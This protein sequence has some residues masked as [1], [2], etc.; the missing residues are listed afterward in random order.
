MRAGKLRQVAPWLGLAALVTA[1]TIARAVSGLRVEG[2]WIVPDEMIYGTLGRSLWEDGDLLVFGDTPGIYGVVYPALVG[3]PLSL[4]DLERG[5]DALKPLQALVMSLAAVPA[6]VWARS[7]AGAWWALLAAALTLAVPDLLYTALVMSEVVF[8]PVM[9]VAAWTIARALERP[10]GWNQAFLVLAMLVAAATRLQA[11]VLPLVLLTAAALFAW[12]ERDF[13]RVRRLWPAGAVLAGLGLAWTLW[14]TLSIGSAADALGAYSVLARTSFGVGDAARYVVYHAADLLLFTGLLAAC[15]VA[16]LFRVRDRPPALNALLATAVSLTGWLLLQVGAFASR[17][18]EV[19]AERNIVLAAPP[20]F[21]CFATWLSLGAPRPRLATSLTALGALG[22]LLLLPLRD[23]VV[24]QGVFQGFMTVPLLWVR[25]Q[26]SEQTLE[27]VVW[28]GAALLLALLVVVPRRF[29]WTL[30]ALVLVALCL[31]STAAT[32]EVTQNVAFDRENLVGGDRRWID[33]AARRPVGVLFA[34]G[35]VNALWHLLFWNERVE[36]VHVLEGFEPEGYLPRS[37]VVTPRPDGTLPGVRE[38]LLVTPAPVAMI[39]QR[40]AR[41][42][43]RLYEPGGL[44]LW[45]IRPPARLDS[46]TA[47]VRENGDMHE[48]A[49]LTAWDCQA[50]RLELTL[51][52][53]LSTRVELRVNGETVRTL[54]LRGEAFVNTT[55]FPPPGAEMCLF[56]VIPDSLL[57]STRFEF[58]RD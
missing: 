45:R 56:E 34:G 49:R 14:R 31:A 46:F 42:T 26:T 28:G 44:V 19:L 52:P 43:Q 6:Y 3:G 30:P 9:I 13:S 50:G 21:V 10:T 51:L 15:S 11:L 48:P 20:L 40:V 29:V 36:T 2:P 53:K 55:V 8:Y 27:L 25:E 23:F 17:F 38:R 16:L 37:D 35:A 12:L 58:V 33:D 4:L 39:G 41:V 5:Y 32:R 47:G 7:L 54:P 57:G 22:L 24:Q 1:S 18:G